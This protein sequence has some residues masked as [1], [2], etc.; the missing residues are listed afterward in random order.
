MVFLKKCYDSVAFFLA[1]FFMFSDKVLN[2][3]RLGLWYGSYRVVVAI[4]LFLIFIFNISQFQQM[5][6]DANFYFGFI[7][8]YL[9]VSLS[10]FLAL[11]FV[12]N[13]NSSHIYLCGLIDVT[14]FSV[15]N[16]SLDQVNIYVGILF[17]ATI[18]IINLVLPNRISTTLTV[19]AVITVVYPPFIKYLFSDNVNDAAILNSLA[20]S[21]L[22]LVVCLIAKISNRYVERLVKINVTQSEV[23]KQT[24]EINNVILDNIDTGHIVI[25]SDFNLIVVNPAAKEIFKI[26]QTDDVNFQE[27][28]PGLCLA[29]SEK[30]SSYSKFDF[31]FNGDNLALRVSFQKIILPEPLIMISIEHLAKLN[32]R[33]QHLKLASLGQLSASIAHEIRNPLACISAANDLFVGS[34]P[35]KVE[36]YVG[37]ISHQCERIDKIIKS[38]LGMARNKEFYPIPIDLNDFFDSL[39][40]EDLSDVSNLVSV[41][42]NTF[43]KIQF[44]EEHLRQVFVN[45]IRNAIRHND[46]E[47]SNHILI[48]A[49]SEG[50]SVLIDVIDYGEGVEK[51]K[52]QNLFNPFFS[53]SVDGTGLGLYLS[54]NLCESNHGNIEYVK[55]GKGACFRVKCRIFDRG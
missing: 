36:R 35:E 27:V 31:D 53:T 14:C 34:G 16:F 17:V 4:S 8:I 45:L 20:L 30:L 5:Y 33:V 55:I 42:I 29:L 6:Y 40:R 32:E 51:S 25:N 24:Q 13:K 9:A 50:D 12:S 11:A 26:S 54:K 7:F 22:F 19:L 49:C 3:Y 28:A 43:E 47:S 2:F 23:L 39:L 41:K 48:E 21:F 10:Q 46:S 37:I 1:C 15:L 52:I 18:F 44:D 38:T